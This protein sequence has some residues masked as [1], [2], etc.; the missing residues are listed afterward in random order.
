MKTRPV[1]EIYQFFKENKDLSENELVS[2][3]VEKYGWTSAIAR[4]L[5]Q[6]VRASDKV[7]E[8]LLTRCRAQYEVI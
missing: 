7:V 6:T 4:D 5:V 2:L 3:S 1:K 8:S